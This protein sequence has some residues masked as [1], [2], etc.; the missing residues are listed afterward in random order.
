MGKYYCSYG[1]LAI[2]FC[3]F[4]YCICGSVAE[5]GLFLSVPGSGS[6]IL[7]SHQIRLP[8]QKTGSWRLQLRNAAVR[9]SCLTFCFRHEFLVALWNV[10]SCIQSCSSFWTLTGFL[11]R[12]PSSMRFVFTVYSILNQNILSQVPVPYLFKTNSFLCTV[13]SEKGILV[14]W[15]WWLMVQHISWCRSD[16]SRV[17]LQTIIHCSIPIASPN[18]HTQIIKRHFCVIE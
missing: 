14:I 13:N 5:S 2:S 7:I 17:I 12:A 11:T 16:G 10:S 6:G 4:A 15:E 1:I 8:L 18:Q 3:H 9:K